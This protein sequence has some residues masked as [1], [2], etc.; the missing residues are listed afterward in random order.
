MKICIYFSK[1]WRENSNLMINLTIMK[2]SLHKDQYPCLIT[3]RSVFFRNRNLSDKCRENQNTPLTLKCFPNKR[4]IETRSGN[5]YCSGMSN[6]SYILRV[7]VCSLGYSA[8]NAHE[9]YCHLWRPAVPYFSTL[10]NK[11][12]N[13]REKLLTW[14]LYFDFLYKFCLIGFQF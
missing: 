12:H 10:S 1:I 14:R 8:C 13:F 11:S 6:K 4:N 5:H 9:R 2:S 3:W 7:C